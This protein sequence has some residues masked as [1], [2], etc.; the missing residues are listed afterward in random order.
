MGTVPQGSKPARSKESGSSLFRLPDGSRS[1]QSVWVWRGFL[2]MSLVGLGLCISLFSTGD[3][4]FAF[5]WVVITLGWFATSMYLWRQHVQWDNETTDR[6]LRG[7][8]Q[9]PAQRGTRK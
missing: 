6:Q 4:T 8:S 3:T 7:G 2:V 9:R 5:L 1:V